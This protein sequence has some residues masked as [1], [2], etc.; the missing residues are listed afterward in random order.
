M[1]IL[2]KLGITVGNN[3]KAEKIFE[4][5]FSDFRNLSYDKPSEYVYKYWEKYKAS[6]NKNNNLNGKVF[7]YILATL[8][9]RERLLPL[10]LNAKVAFVPNVEY[11]L[12]FF[13]KEVGPIVISAKTS[14]RERYKQADLEAIVLKNV[15]RNSLTFLVTLDEKEANNAQQKIFSGDIV[16]LDKVIIATS[17]EFD[18]MINKIKSF[19]LIE[20]QTIEIINSTH[21]INQEKISSIIDI[22]E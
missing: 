4:S 20:N 21:V 2:N 14:L 8:C 3:N 1:A 7:E 10:F 19:N 9:I 17:N 22:E 18:Q 5:L 15:H 16:G 13:S 12:M 11:D 6:N